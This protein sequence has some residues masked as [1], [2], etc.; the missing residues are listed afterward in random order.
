[1]ETGSGVKSMSKVSIK[2]WACRLLLTL[3]TWFLASS[4]L[5]FIQT[6]RQLISPLIP[7]SVIIDI[8]RASSYASLYVAVLF[9]PSLWL[10]F[11]RKL[12]IVICLQVISIG[13]FYLSQYL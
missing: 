7:Q 3:N 1:M 10:Y 13:A 12:T 2:E 9:L 11:Y 4:L 5:S 8:I 6:K